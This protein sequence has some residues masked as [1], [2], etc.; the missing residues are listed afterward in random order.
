MI[1][2]DAQIIR[3]LAAGQIE[4][5]GFMDLC[6]QAD[7]KETLQVQL[8]WLSVLGYI[9]AKKPFQ[10]FNTDNPLFSHAVSAL[11]RHA[12]E[13]ELVRIFDQTFVECLTQVRAL[14]QI[15]PHNL[16]A[17][18]QRQRSEA[19]TPLPAIFSLSLDAYE[20]RL[21]DN[22]ADAYHDLTLYF[23]WDLVC[24]CFRAVFD[25]QSPQ[26]HV[27]E[28]IKVFKWC[29]LESFQ[30]IARDK[31]TRPSFWSL[32]EVLY[33]YKMRE[34]KLQ[35][36]TDEEWLM[37]CQMAAAL[38]PQEEISDVY[39]VDGAVVALENAHDSLFSHAPLTVFTLDS[40]ARVDAGLAFAHH[41]MDNI[42]GQAIPW[43]VSLAPVRV[44]CLDEVGNSVHIARRI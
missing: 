13:S 6:A 32:L 25:H 26:G 4:G 41:V 39:Y 31:R 34:E 5:R 23:A 19:N 40:V 28:G 11:V 15:H 24:A 17:H 18:I 37:L 35:G 9:G 10:L 43:G 16:L 33:A 36:Y 30:H 44:I 20:T 3:K 21:R 27:F 42:A 1:Y 38:R 8:S 14:P 12:P 22:P 2:F 29:L 7:H